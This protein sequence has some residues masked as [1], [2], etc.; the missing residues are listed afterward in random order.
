MCLIRGRSAARGVT[1]LVIVGLAWTSVRSNEGPPRTVDDLPSLEKSLH[2]LY[3]KVAP[4]TVNLFVEPKHEH[5]G[6]GVVIDAKGL[7]LTHAHQRQ[8]PGTRFSVGLAPG[9]AVTA[10]FPDG[11]KAPGKVLGVHEPA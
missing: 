11:K 4:S 1:A 7:V 6:S 9:T 8:A 3:A 2:E 5:V 10:V